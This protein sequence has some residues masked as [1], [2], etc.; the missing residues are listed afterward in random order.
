MASPIDPSEDGPLFWWGSP[1]ATNFG[2]YLSKVVVERLAH[3]R[4]PDA[5]ASLSSNRRLLLAVGSIIHFA[6]DGDV[7]WGSGFRESPLQEDRRYRTLDVRAVRG[8]ISRDYLLQMGIACPEVYGDPALL[9]PRLCP[10]LPPVEQQDECIVIPNCGEM[11]YFRHYRH[12]VMPKEPWTEIVAAI[13]RSRLVISSSLHGLIVAE[14]FGVPARLLK[15]TWIEPMLK[16]EDCYRATGRDRFAWATSV[17]EAV[18]MGGARAPVI[19]LQPLIDSF[20]GLPG[21]PAEH[22]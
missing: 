5:P 8:P 16:Y 6:R 19:D 1:N 3:V 18:E 2:D 13:R 9:L 10:D 15:M 21:V 20:P 22:A 17:G 7:V 11:D 12:V 4:L 14:A